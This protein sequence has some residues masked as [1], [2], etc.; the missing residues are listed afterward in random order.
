MPGRRGKGI[1]AG[2]ASYAHSDKPRQPLV[3]TPE[4]QRERALKRWAAHRERVAQGPDAVEAHA[5]V[6]R[7]KKVR[8]QMKKEK[9]ALRASAI[10]SPACVERA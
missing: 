2:P 4:M 5:R 8:L 7:F 3:L 9:R 10:P 1:G 6:V